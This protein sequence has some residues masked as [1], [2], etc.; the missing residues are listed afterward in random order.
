MQYLREG[1]IKT[2]KTFIDP[3]RLR[4]P[5]DSIETVTVGDQMLPGVIKAREEFDDV[6]AIW[7]WKVPY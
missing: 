4:E 7:P 5:T 2:E 3:I 6:D 1:T